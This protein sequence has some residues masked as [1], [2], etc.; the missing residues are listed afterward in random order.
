M[1]ISKETLALINTFKN[2][3]L[4]TLIKWQKNS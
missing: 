3:L 1:T 4:E 2:P